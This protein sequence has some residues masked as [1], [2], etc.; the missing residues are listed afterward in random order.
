MAIY[1]FTSGTSA[2]CMELD[3]NCVW[4][5]VVDLATL[6]I[7]DIRINDA[8]CVEK[9]LANQPT[10]TIP[11]PTPGGCTISGAIG[12]A[13]PASPENCIYYNLWDALDGLDG[14]KKVG[15]HYEI[16]NKILTNISL[17][18][19]HFYNMELTLREYLEAVN[20]T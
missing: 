10:I 3:A 19:S 11:G 5:R 1:R 2:H 6:D 7:S 17:Y 13:A 18:K 14:V 16:T 20:D 15:A 9:S 12:I 4:H 8:I